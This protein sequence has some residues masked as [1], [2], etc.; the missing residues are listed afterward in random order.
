MKAP[1]RPP[2]P[3]SK[4]VPRAAHA[5][6]DFDYW[7]FVTTWA[8][9]LC[10]SKP[11]LCLEEKDGTLLKAGN[12]FSSHGLWPTLYQDGDAAYK[13]TY[14][15]ASTG[16]RVPGVV[17]SSG[18]ED[19][20]NDSGGSAGGAG[21]RPPRKLLRSPQ[22]C[23]PKWAREQAERHNLRVHAHTGDGDRLWHQWMKHGSCSGL[24]PPQYFQQEAVLGD[25][26]DMHNLTRHVK[27]VVQTCIHLHNNPK[28]PT[29]ETKQPL[30]PI[31]HLRALHILLGH[32]D[33]SKVA[34]K[35]TGR[36]QLEEITTCWAK[37]EGH[38]GEA[39]VGGQIACPDS[40]LRSA[41]NS[42]G[43]LGC[44]SVALDTSAPLRLRQLQSQS[45]GISSDGGDDG[46]QN[47]MNGKGTNG[48]KGSWGSDA[49]ER[50]CSF[51]SKAFLR[52][53]KG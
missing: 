24:S 51:I 49:D 4:P 20:S 31:L 25:G 33:N 13:Y 40:I 15:G 45:S 2:L 22:Y 12:T 29:F 32:D 52:E 9:R 18:G 35:A 3:A 37:V 53:L 7:L 38:K 21:S 5:K 14:K 16:T 43:S 6:P 26:A 27:A 46:I 41:R 28:M 50:Q 11:E 47:K 39:I 19:C 10:C 23:R 17:G 42:A 1:D 36:C 30:P 48:G 34:V 8:P 44:T